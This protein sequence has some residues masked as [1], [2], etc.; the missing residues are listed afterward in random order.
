MFLYLHVLDRNQNC[1]SGSNSIFLCR[2][3]DAVRMNHSV[4]CTI[5][6]AR[7]SHDG[8]KDFMA[9]PSGEAQAAL[10]KRV[11]EDHG[12]SPADT[13]YIEAHGTGTDAGDR[14]ELG[15][16]HSAM[17]EGIQGRPS[18]E[19][20]LVG[21]V[22]SNCG[23]TEGAAGALGVAKVMAGEK[24]VDHCCDVFWLLTLICC[25]QFQVALM[26]Y[27][28]LIP[29]SLHMK[30]PHPLIPLEAYAMDVPQSH[31][32]W[33]KVRP[34]MLRRAAVN[35][36][37]IGGS[38]AHVLLEE[39]SRPPSINTTPP[40]IA[41]APYVLPLSGHTK[42]ALFESVNVW[43]NFLMDKKQDFEQD[44]Q[45]LLQ[46]LHQ[47]VY[48]RS[49]MGW[50]LCAIGE[51]AEDLGLALKQ[52]L[53]SE[54][55]A[56]MNPGEAKQAPELDSSLVSVQ[57]SV[58]SSS[59]MMLENG[60]SGDMTVESAGDNTDDKGKTVNGEV[61]VEDPKKT[62]NGGPTEDTNS[63]L[64]QR[65][66]LFTSTNAKA[67]GRKSLLFVFSGQGTQYTGMGVQLYNSEQVF[68]DVLDECNGFVQD[69]G[70]TFCLITEL[71][72]SETD[73][74]VM[75]PNI[76]LVLL[77]VVQ[78]C[79]VELLKFNGIEASGSLGHSSGEVAAAYCSGSL[80]RRDAVLLALARSK[81]VEEHALSLS[82]FAPRMTV[83]GTSQQQAEEMVKELDIDEIKDGKVVIAAINSG[84]SVTLSGDQPAVELVELHCKEKN[85]R[86]H[87]LKI[88]AAFH[89]HHMTEV[90]EALLKDLSTLIPTKSVHPLFSP[91]TGMSP[92]LTPC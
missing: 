28:G 37:G 23:H 85:I 4:Y 9:F 91:V 71:H 32:E 83:V 76:S 54:Q 77:P 81:C 35:S 92:H 17:M 29:P 73:S 80:S 7:S 69:E 72:K 11:Y 67:T 87:V 43:Y 26:L 27:H 10:M 2:V 68:R 63:V 22:K 21:S 89:S 65:V 62:E 52:G 42:K 25:A 39:F 16:I 44:P 55:F 88:G 3:Q 50:R 57:K 38:N 47:V 66:H 79:L 45:L 41:Q 53:E 33:P 48:G 12:L 56:E 82:A 84:M 46:S 1:D 13:Q 60:T 74:G 34:G 75:P 58:N 15:S 18:G 78:I 64:P 31:S 59:G 49:H 5:R 36:F 14:T 90:G 51:C 61:D 20:L 40:Q 19:K 30:N 24:S 86:T 70:G 6:G 8:N